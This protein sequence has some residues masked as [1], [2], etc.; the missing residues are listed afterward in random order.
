MSSIRQHGTSRQMTSLDFGKLVRGISVA[1]NA[2]LEL[3]KFKRSK[4]RTTYVDKDSITRALEEGD[5]VFL[6]NLS[7]Y[8]YSISGIYSRFIEYLAGI[9]TYSWY[10]Y[11]YMLKDKYSSK[12]VIKDM[13]NILSYLDNLSIPSIFYDISTTIIRDGVF[14]GYMINNPTKTL[15]T[16]LELPI[17]YC[18]SRYKYNGMDAV[19][20]NVKYFDQQFL[21]S[22][23]RT[24][25][26][27][28]FPKE[29]LKN[30]QAY[31]NGILKVDRIDNGAWF[32]CDPSL[33]MKFS[34]PNG[35][36][37]LF[38]SVVPTILNLEEAKELD[39][40]KTL[41]EL[42]KIIVQKMPLDKNSELVFDLDESAAM[43]RNACNMLTNA[44]NVDV[45][46]TF[47][48]VDILDLDN[49][50]VTST[51]DPLSKVERGVFNEAGISQMLFATD[52]NIALEKSIMNDEAI[53]FYLLKLYQNKLNSI[54]DSLFNKRGIY[55][56]GMPL[57]SIY[58][59]E[60]KQKMY[61]EMASAGYSKLMPAIAS[62]I[63]QTE[64]L[65]LNEYENEILNLNEKMI[66]LQIS[67][68]QSSTGAGASEKK[69]GAPPKPDD[70]KTEKT[71]KNKESQV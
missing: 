37:P 22:E 51:K 26:L 64:F 28:N 55:K 36:T 4:Y 57:L 49:S 63:T 71:I 20:F 1:D 33:S 58:N 70:E 27:Q 7:N 60:K 11:P 15:G 21:D 61:K 66:P 52:G 44:V 34:F 67:S 39:M 10:A 9:L 47:A 5:T 46:T 30:Y 62:G 24:L 8:F 3:D 35:D 31:K 41:Q 45:L 50:T 16:I 14:Y 6:R 65:S 59:L 43:H 12:N 68:T 23:T 53:M 17:D 56:I 29:F 54:I 13:N 19:E 48:E 2:V 42:L 25:V 69:V 38:I 40:K 32:L 18:R